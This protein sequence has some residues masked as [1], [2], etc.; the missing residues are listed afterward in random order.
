MRIVLQLID[1]SLCTRESSNSCQLGRWMALRRML[2][3]KTVFLLQ[4]PHH[5]GFVFCFVCLFCFTIYLMGSVGGDVYCIYGGRSEDSLWKLLLSFPYVDL[6]DW[7]QAIVLGNKC[8]YC[9]SHPIATCLFVCFNVSY[10][11]GCEL[12]SD[13]G[14]H[15]LMAVVIWIGMSPIDSWVWMFGT[16]KRCGLTGSRCGLVC[17]GLYVSL[18]GLALRSPVLKLHPVWNSVSLLSED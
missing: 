2:T 1:G 5:T 6:R 14:F 9:L 8:L 10:P 11:P 7:T 18:W 3:E 4:P 16:I 15:W 17:G 12:M 13:Y